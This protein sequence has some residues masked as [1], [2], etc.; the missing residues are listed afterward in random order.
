MATARLI[1]IDQDDRQDIQ[2]DGDNIDV[3][4]VRHDA[5]LSD[6]RFAFEA[7]GQRVD[8]DAAEDAFDERVPELGAPVQYGFSG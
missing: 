6:A 4:E 3:D 8:V 2:T 1:E 5:A 7:F